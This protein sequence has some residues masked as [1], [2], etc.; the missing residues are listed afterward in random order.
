MQDMVL[1]KCFSEP[2]NGTICFSDKISLLIKSS[3]YSFQLQLWKEQYSVHMGACLQTLMTWNRYGY[4]LNY[5]PWWWWCCVMGMMMTVMLMLMVIADGHGRGCYNS[6]D[7]DGNVMM[8]MMMVVMM[9]LMM[10]VVMVMIMV[11]ML[12]MMMTTTMTMVMVRMM[13]MMMMNHDVNITWSVM[14]SGNVFS[15]PLPGAAHGHSKW[16]F[17]MWPTVVRPWWGNFLAIYYH[18]WLYY[19]TLGKKLAK[20]RNVAKLRIENTISPM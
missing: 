5:K 6:D 19:H 1:G 10:T 7:D 16:G 9:M 14:P 8:V 11:V 15:D 3:N 2:E 18:L 12:M 17:G 4:I 13:V 20:P